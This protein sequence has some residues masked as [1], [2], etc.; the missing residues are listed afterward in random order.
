MTGWRIGWIAGNVEVVERY[1]QLKTNL[2]SGMF[3]ALQHAGAAALTAARDFP[4]EMS[5]V[6]RRRRDLML[7]ALERHMPEGTTWTRP[8]G[9]FFVWVTFPPGL[10]T[11]RMLP[12]AR[13]RGVEFL[14]GATCYMD[15][16]GRDQLRL[17]YSFVSDDQIEPGIK[18][19]GEIAR[20]ELLEA[21]RA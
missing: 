14:P 19:I 17:S 4:A 8:D 5:E 9:G 1:R 20:G 7:A 12:Q 11:T 10:D 6:Y 18:V 15:G 2:D 16:R 3:D 13:E 21:G